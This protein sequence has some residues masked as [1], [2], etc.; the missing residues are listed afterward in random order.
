MT[1][2]TTARH[3]LP[4][5][6]FAAVALWLA[7]SSD[8][9]EL[10]P[11]D[12]GVEASTIDAIFPPLPPQDADADVPPAPK[13]TRKLGLEIN[14]PEDDDYYAAL[15]R[16]RE[17]GVEITNVSLGWDDLE[18]PPPTAD[19]G[20]DADPDAASDAG[21]TYFNASLHV[22]N[23]VLPAVGLAA[24]VTVRTV[25]SN[26]SHVPADLAQRSFDDP[27]VLA[28]FNA[29]QDYLLGELPD[30][31]IAVYVIGNDVD[32]SFGEDATKYAAYKT[33]FDGASAYAK[34]KRPGLKVG[35]AA[36]LAGLVGP[37]SAELSSLNAS[38][39]YVVVTY[40][41][42]ASDFTARDPASARQDFALLA[43]IYPNKPIYVREA[44]YP[45]SG[46]LGSSAEKQADFVRAMFA[47]WDER[48][49]SVSV[50]TFF[51][52]HEYRQPALDALTRY[53]GSSDPRFVEYLRT[54]GLR[55][56][57]GAGADKP[58]FGALASEAK[59][60]GF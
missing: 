59:R 17:A 5:A 29:A 9:T 30:L 7:C 25:D 21:P 24:S 3:V 1:P 2:R 53:Y 52:M 14:A 23:L 56:A 58:A 50:V 22:A 41:P 44:R 48:R 51:P 18:I 19:A 33:F 8:G 55:A 27:A 12:A 32:V 37:R 13:G 34:Q 40:S 42:V 31:S 43:Q 4:P 39:D 10:R 26:G 6:C 60:R 36:T 15:V 49:A 35:A 45:S 16:A 57:S 54:L 46:A 47:A 11:S 28:R 38:S 20:T